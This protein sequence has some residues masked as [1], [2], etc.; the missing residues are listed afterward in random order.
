M[1]K[2]LVADRGLWAGASR[3][4]SSPVARAPQRMHVTGLSKSQAEQLL[5]WLEA[6]GYRDYDLAY[7]AGKAFT[8]SYS[9]DSAAT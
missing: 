1:S 4:H 5:D 2:Q 7:S 8:V 3:I 9:N 6:N